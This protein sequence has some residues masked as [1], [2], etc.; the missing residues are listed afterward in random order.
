M[1]GGQNF[2]SKINKATVKDCD[3]CRNRILSRAL[4]DVHRIQ[5]VQ[6]HLSCKR[7][8]HPAIGKGLGLLA[9]VATLAVISHRVGLHDLLTHLHLLQDTL[10][11][12][13]AWGYL[14]YAALFI[15]A[16]LCLIPGSLLVIAGG[17]LFGPLTGS[18]L[19]FAA[20]TL[21]SSLSF[22]IA[23][24]LGR[25]LLQR[26]VGHTTVFQAIERGIARSGCDFLILTR[27]VPLFPYNIQN[28]AY[29][30][31]AI[32][33]WP[34]T[35]ISAVTTLPGLVIYSVMASELARE[36]VTLAFALK[37][38]LAG[39]LLFAL[40]QIGKRFARARRVAACSEEVR[41]DPT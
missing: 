9:L 33:F 4:F 7:S 31:T 12:Q 38:S 34:F 21:A 27:L 25:D 2:L 24:W 14:V 29:G 15:I 10:R 37:L 8:R 11:H 22:L 36:G 17:M 41:H 16:T 30:L 19:S 23:R 40:V 18:L 28:Y 13:G 32:R 1:C 35:L 39:G 5:T 6:E 26:Y 3:R 20:A